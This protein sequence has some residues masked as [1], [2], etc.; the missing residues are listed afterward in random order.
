MPNDYTL[1]LRTTGPAAAR[2]SAR[3][4]TRENATVHATTIW[5]RSERRLQV[6]ED[7]RRGFRILEDSDVRLFERKAQTQ[8]SNL[9]NEL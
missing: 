8:K 6:V 9:V 1:P 2:T 7:A 3:D 5:F 4:A